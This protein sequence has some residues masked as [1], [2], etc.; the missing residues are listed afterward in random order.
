MARYFARTRALSHIRSRYLNANKT[1]FGTL[2]AVVIS[3]YCFKTLLGQFYEHQ[4]DSIPYGL[5]GM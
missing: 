3:R 1:D 4:K 2:V 5:F